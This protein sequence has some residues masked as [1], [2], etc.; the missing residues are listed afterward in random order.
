MDKKIETAIRE[1]LV[2]ENKQSIKRCVH[3]LKLIFEQEQQLSKENLK[4]KSIMKDIIK[5]L[6]LAENELTG[7]PSEE[8]AAEALLLIKDVLQVLRQTYVSNSLPLNLTIYK[9]AQSMSYE[10]FCKWFNER[11]E[12]QNNYIGSLP[13]NVNVDE[14]I[15]VLEKLILNS[16]NIDADGEPTDPIL[17]IVDTWL[18]ASDLLCRL[19]Q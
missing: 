19:R 17:D 3:K 1:T 10:D 7:E 18:K 14:I 9:N 5:K 4:N 2:I 13:Q 6:E 8:N 15:D 16:H 11:V 12:R